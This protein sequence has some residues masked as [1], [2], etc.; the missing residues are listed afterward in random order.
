M[1]TARTTDFL[2]VGGGIVGLCIARELRARY[3]DASITLIDKE[4]SLGQHASGRNSGVLHAGFY[5]TADSLKARFCRE[6]NVTM[7]AYCDARGLA[8][9][10]CGKLVV[11]KNA[12]ELATLD[13]L[14]RRAAGN[15]VPVESLSAKEARER[16]PRVK[17]FERALWSPTTAS[18]HPPD[19]V[20]AMHAD[21][22]AEGIEVRTGVAYT[23][24]S[25]HEVHTSAGPIGAGYVV[26]AAGLYADRVARDFGFSKRYRILPFKGLYL[27]SNEPVGALRTS[28]YPVPDLKNP[29]LGVHFTVTA[30]GHAKI[31]PTA[32][33]C[34]W[35]EQYGWTSNFKFGELMQIA[36]LSLGLLFRAGFDFRGLAREEMRKYHRG[37]LVSKAS[38]LIEGMRPE[39]WTIWGKPGIRAQLLDVERRTLVMDFCTEGDDASF[40]VLNAVSPAF[41]CSIPIARHVCDQ[42]HGL[43]HGTPRAVAS[44]TPGHG[45]RERRAAPDSVTGDEHLTSKER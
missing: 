38:E 3:T 15:G 22:I 24:R 45:P 7:R 29:F 30:D 13:E 27:Y 9:N 36:G 28:V 16:E 41:T 33:P 18:V 25:G 40:H 11:V 44:G 39:D 42:I 4:S 26:N 21:A 35:R 14:L 2:V 20:A 37:Y 17:T 43:L 5:Y 6:G 31:G 12:A 8:I 34:L 32:I 23:G 1:N 19:V 10:P